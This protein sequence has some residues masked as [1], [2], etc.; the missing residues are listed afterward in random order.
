MPRK[1]FED[2]RHS[3]PH[4]GLD[5]GPETKTEQEYLPVAVQVKRFLNAG[6]ILKASKLEMFDMGW[7][8]DFNLNNTPARKIYMNRVEAKEAYDEAI[9]RIKERGTAVK[10]PEPDTAENT[11]EQPTEQPEKTGKEDSKNESKKQ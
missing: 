2:Y 7:D 5:T 6:E 4:P 10:K 1:I 11:M 8:E 9:E 3:V